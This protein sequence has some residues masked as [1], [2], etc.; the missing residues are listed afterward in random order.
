MKSNLIAIWLLLIL[1]AVPFDAVHSKKPKRKK[2]K[3]GL[4]SC[5]AKTMGL[6]SPFWGYGLETILRKIII[7]ETQSKNLIITF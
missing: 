2:F 7:A 1:I 5:S 4:L 6:V 3:G